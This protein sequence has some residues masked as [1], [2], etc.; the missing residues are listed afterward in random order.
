MLYRL[1]ARSVRFVGRLVFFSLI[2][3]KKNSN[4]TKFVDNYSS[5]FRVVDEEFRQW[6]IRRWRV[7]QTWMKNKM[8]VGNFFFWWEFSHAVLVVPYSFFCAVCKTWAELTSYCTVIMSIWL[9]SYSGHPPH[10]QKAEQQQTDHR[11][12]QQITGRL[13][14]LWLNATS[15]SR[16]E[17]QEFHF[18]YHQFLRLL[19]FSF[20]NSFVNT[21]VVNSVAP[22]EAISQCWLDW[23]DGIGNFSPPSPIFA[24]VFSYPQFLFLVTPQDFFSRG[25]FSPWRGNFSANFSPARTN[26][27]RAKLELCVSCDFVLFFLSGLIFFSFSYV[28]F[29]FFFFFNSRG[30]FYGRNGSLDNHRQ[31]YNIT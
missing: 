23:V 2:V 4:N 31:Q 26:S 6:S 30:G 21:V 13:R 8:L 17:E 27:G 28:I 14:R 5:T 10:R 12:Q 29:F 24:Q 18:H 3:G 25:R 15:R 1:I 9:N 16:G 11:H 7:K 19:K 20:S 22:P